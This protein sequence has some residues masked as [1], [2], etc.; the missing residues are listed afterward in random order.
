MKCEKCG[1]NLFLGGRNCPSCGRPVSPPTDG[2]AMSRAEFF[3]LALPQKFQSI[4]HTGI[5]IC[6]FS[7]IV[8]LILSFWMPLS[9]MLQAALCLVIAVGLQITKSVGWAYLGTVLSCGSLAIS[10]LAEGNFVCLITLIGCVFACVGSH[11]LSVAYAGYLAGGKTPEIGEDEGRAMVIK[12]GKRRNFRIVTTAVG[13]LVIGALAIS[14]AIFCFVGQSA[15]RDYAPGK[16]E[17]NGRYVNGFADISMNLPSDWIV[18]DQKALADRS[19][20]SEMTGE[21]VE[22]F[23][24]SPD[25]SVTVRLDIVRQSS[26]IYTAKDL[27][28]SYADS[29]RLEAEADSRDFSAGQ[30]ES[31]TLGGVE[32]LCLVARIAEEGGE[33][34]RIYL[35]RQIGSYSVIFRLYAPSDAILDEFSGWFEP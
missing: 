13:G 17:K 31:R 28:E 15:D 6:Y 11:A 25:R 16:L 30:T 27:L 9:G 20:G 29:V 2:V 7:V 22:F 35:C 3:R 18:Y 33:S 4:L 21:G 12:Y 34:S 32:Y 26:S 8:S 19:I 14:S 5:L 24:L 23:A 1:A 10:V